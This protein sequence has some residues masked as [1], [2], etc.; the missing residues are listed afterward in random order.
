MIWL[1]HVRGRPIIRKRLSWHDSNS[2]WTFTVYECIHD[3]IGSV[4]FTMIKCNPVTSDRACRLKVTQ[5]DPKD[6]ILGQSAHT[7]K[8]WHQLKQV[9]LIL[10]LPFFTFFVHLYFFLSCFLARHTNSYSS[11]W[12]LKRTHYEQI[13]K[14]VFLWLYWSFQSYRKAFINDSWWLRNCISINV[15][16]LILKAT[17][18]QISVMWLCFLLQVKILAAEFWMSWRWKS[19]FCWWQKV[20]NY[21]SLINWLWR[22]DKCFQMFECLVFD[23]WSSS[24]SDQHLAAGN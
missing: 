23:V 6:R 9:R 4:S 5:A 2:K 17:E 14:S 24:L 1:Y 13:P 15:L 11:N 18:S 3:F 22:R 16:K 7:L 20:R 12:I 21:S 8:G 19:N 10:I